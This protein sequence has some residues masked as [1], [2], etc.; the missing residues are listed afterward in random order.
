M[1]RNIWYKRASN[2]IDGIGFPWK[3]CRKQRPELV[4]IERS[5]REKQSCHFLWYWV[6]AIVTRFRQEK[7]RPNRA[8]KHE[9]QASERGRSRLYCKLGFERLRF[10]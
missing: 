3:G 1:V 2:E 7:G 6:V 4:F 5:I 8:G 9:F 10:Q